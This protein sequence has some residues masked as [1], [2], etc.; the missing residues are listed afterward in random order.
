ML[1]QAFVQP[2]L[3]NS[4]QTQLTWLIFDQLSIFLFCQK[5]LEKSC[6]VNYVIFFFYY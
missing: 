5:I 6:L 1:K 3:K 4:T 2:V